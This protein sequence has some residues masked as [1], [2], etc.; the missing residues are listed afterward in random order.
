MSMFYCY[1]RLH[2]LIFKDTQLKKRST[3]TSTMKIFQQPNC[4]YSCK[5]VLFETTVQTGD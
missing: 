5:V 2:L 1:K 4:P 3:Q